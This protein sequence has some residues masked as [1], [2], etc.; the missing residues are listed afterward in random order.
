[1]RIHAHIYEVLLAY[2][3]IC[4]C[5]QSSLYNVRIFITDYLSLN[6]SVMLYIFHVNKVR[7]KCMI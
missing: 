4:I 7:Y 2:H 6:A 3:S 1:M 5:I